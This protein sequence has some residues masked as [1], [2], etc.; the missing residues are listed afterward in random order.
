MVSHDA[1]FLNRAVTAV[2]AVEGRRL[3]K[4]PGNYAAYQAKKE[5]LEGERLRQYT[6]QRREIARTEAYI[7]K[8]RA[9]RNAKM[10]RGRQKKLDRLERLAA[11][12]GR[13]A[14]PVFE[15]QPLPAGRTGDLEVVGLSV[16]YRSP[17]LEGLD[18]SVH[19]GQ[20][21]VL[22]GFNGVGKST[23]LNTLAGR[24]PPLAGRFRFSEQA[25]LGYFPQALAWTDGT[26]TPEE[27]VTGAFPA[28]D[29]QE[30][31]RALARCGVRQEHALQ[32]VAT[33][34]G[35]EQARVKLCLLTLR[36][37]NFLLL[38]EPTN[39]LDR[40]AKE[41]LARALDR[42]PGTVLLVSHEADFYRA[43]AQRVVEIGGKGR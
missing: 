3:T 26:R 5:C 41:A 30:A 28:L 42:F 20:K 18:L 1:A 36:P 33:L 39:H 9:G 27:L 2:C 21:V 13:S 10:A 8:N 6:A 43:W 7:R 11:P 12:E 40:A 19:A 32:A 34:S 4:Y 31:R 38:D 14:P 15:F 25:A 35:G 37:C 24:L 29:R 23:L 22:T 17:V 16:G